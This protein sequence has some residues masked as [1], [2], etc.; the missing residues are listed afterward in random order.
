MAII[1]TFKDEIAASEAVYENMKSFAQYSALEIIPNQIDGLKLIHRRIIWVL[2]TSD[3]RKKCAALTGEVMDK[4]HPHGDV[5]ITDSIVRLAQP[6]NQC[7]PLVF[8]DGNFGAYGGGDAA[9]GRY[10]DVKSAPFARDLF[11]NRVNTKTLTYIPSETGVGY[12]PAYLVPIIPTAFLMGAF[13]IAVGFKSNIPHYNLNNVCDLVEKFL[14]LRKDYPLDYYKRYSDIAKYCIPDYPSHTLLRNEKQLLKA[15]SQGDYS[16]STICDGFIEIYPNKI[17]LHTIPYGRLFENAH[18]D[19]GNEFKKSSS[20]LASMVQEITELTTGWEFGNIEIILKRGLDPFEALDEIKKIVRFT[21]SYKPIWNFTDQNGA[22]SE[23]NPMELLETWYQARYRSILAD[24]KMTNMELFKLYRKLSALIIIA[25]HTN[26]VLNIFKKAENKTATIPP[27]KEKFKLT[28]EQAEFISDLP[29]HTIT[30]Q[31]KEDLLRRLNNTKD[32]IKE[33][34]TK[35]VNI[36]NIILEDVNY[37]RKQYGNKSPRRTEIPNFVGALK[38]GTNGYVQVRSISELN[39]LLKRWTNT[40]C[41][42]IWYPSGEK[43]ILAPY[44][45]RLPKD[46]DISLPREFRADDLYI[47][48]TKPTCT[49]MLTN[50]RV[51]RYEGI[52]FPKDGHKA[53]IIG[54]YFIAIYA[55]GTVETLKYTDIDIR[56]KHVDL[57]PDYVYFGSIAY[58]DFIVASVTDKEPNLVYFTRINKEGKINKHL[59]G[60]LSIIG[61]WKSTDP[62]VFTVADKHLSRCSTRHV[63][64]KDMLGIMDD[65]NE[66]WVHLNRK[67]FSNKKSLLP[68]CRNAQVFTDQPIKDKNENIKKMY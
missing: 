46:S 15:F 34:Q 35:F 27:L 28:R 31:S 11:F 54:T 44:N 4:V 38:I 5:A 60:A 22:L 20:K 58:D 59:L 18:K 2:G 12:E 7:Q 52:V 50:N 32:K 3:T 45:Q 53:W 64:I 25:D 16:I 21:S 37:I 17:N 39:F 41:E 8:T 43:Q 61:I 68:L 6:F 51:A 49:L 55:D 26:A 67:V 36:D 14:K 42:I 33:L 62:I 57:L 23:L 19:L 10:L 48:K 66:A 56:K 1:T 9:A 63:Y 65:S 40:S 29:L 30:K 47:L 24:L 13:T